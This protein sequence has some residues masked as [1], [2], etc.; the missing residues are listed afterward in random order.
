LEKD[1]F[2]FNER[3]PELAMEQGE[4]KVRAKVEV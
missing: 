1:W 2:D 4:K 3:L